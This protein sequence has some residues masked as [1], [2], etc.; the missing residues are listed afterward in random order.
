MKAIFVDTSAY[1]AYSNG[2]PA[3]VEVVQAASALSISIVTLAELLAG[4]A[5][6]S[7]EAQNLQTLDEFQSVGAVG[8]LPVD[9]QTAETYARVYV[10]LRRDGKLIPTNDMF[11]AA[12]AP[13]HG[14]ALFTYDA[15][16]R[17][18]AGLRV[19]QTLADLATQT[20]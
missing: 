18:V 14:L 5:A 15:H 19:V 16:F 12:T 1:T 6:G 10:Q 13:R 8:V 9:R 7:R 17:H 3:A 20:A 2:Q 11:I 4:V